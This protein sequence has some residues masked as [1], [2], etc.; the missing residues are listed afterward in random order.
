MLKTLL[1]P[2]G[3]QVTYSNTLGR[4]DNV[5]L[6]TGE[7]VHRSYDPASGRLQG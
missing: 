5:A 1:R 7:N 3:D 4:L 6:P 2:E